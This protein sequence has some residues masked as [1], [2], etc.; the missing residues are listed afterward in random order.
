MIEQKSRQIDIKVLTLTEPVKKSGIADPTEFFTES[1]WDEAKGLMEQ[2]GLFGHGFFLLLSQL[3]PP[4]IGEFRQSKGQINSQFDNYTQ[5]IKAPVKN[6]EEVM[7]LGADLKTVDPERF[8]TLKFPKRVFDRTLSKL[9]RELTD[10]NAWGSMY[11]PA[12]FP[13]CLAVV[14]PQHTEKIAASNNVAS[15]LRD[16]FEYSLRNEE[17]DVFVS[18]AAAMRILLPEDF[19]EN[20]EKIV[21]ALDERMDGEHLMNYNDLLGRPATIFDK[22]FNGTHLKMLRA[23]EVKITPRGLS[24]T[25]SK[26]VVNLKPESLPK[27]RNF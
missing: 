23:E 9:D 11:P 8:A 26:D 27:K 6:W 22:V 4:S 13:L 18:T 2:P 7:M 12:F 21:Q 25:M 15:R 5:G 10:R 17:W 3:H 16:D 24:M 1:D 19:E 20:R 14:F